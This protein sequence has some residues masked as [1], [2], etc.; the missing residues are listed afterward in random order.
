MRGPAVP[1]EIGG[2]GGDEIASVVEGEVA[3]EPACRVAG[4]ARLLEAREPRVLDERRGVLAHERVP[5]V[6]RDVPDPLD[7]AELEARAAPPGSFRTSV[8]HW[9][10]GL[11]SL[12]ATPIETWLEMPRR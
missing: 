4:A 2:R 6:L 5:S 12:N 1:V 10:R 9:W 7:D 8:N 11:P 3:R